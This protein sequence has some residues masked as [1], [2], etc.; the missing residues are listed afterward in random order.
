ML[1]RNSEVVAKKTGKY[2]YTYT[3]HMSSIL[4]RICALHQPKL[5]CERSLKFT[6]RLQSKYQHHY[7][8]TNVMHFLFSLLRIKGLYMFRALLA[9]L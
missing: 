2:V 8:K 9:H 6:H 1:D 7:S 5:A 4:L 3:F